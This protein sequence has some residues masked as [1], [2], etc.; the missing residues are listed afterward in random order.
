MDVTG[1]GEAGDPYEITFTIPAGDLGINWR[2]AYSGATVYATRDDVL[3]NGSAWIA[4]QA[5]TD[6][7]PPVLPT[8]ANA[9]WS[10]VAC[11]PGAEF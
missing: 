8:T 9:Y 4:L 3:D 7:A 1:S 10:L 5:T 6:D 11:I 2:G